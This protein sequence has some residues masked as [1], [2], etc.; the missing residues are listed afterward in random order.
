MP[1]S[2]RARKHAYLVIAHTDKGALARLLEGVDDS[3]ND[4]FVHLDSRWAVEGGDFSSCVEESG[5]SFVRRIHPA[6][7]GS[8]LIRVEL[9]L[10]RAATSSGRY[11]YYH[12]L[13][14][15]D[16]PVKS[17]DYIH[18]YFQDDG[19]TC[20]LQASDEPVGERAA[21]RFRMRYE[22]YHLLQDALIGK[23]RNAWKYLE[24]SFCHLQRLVGVRR[25]KGVQ[26]RSAWQW[27]SLPDWA[28]R[29]LAQHAGEI[30]RRWRYTYCCDELFIPTELILAGFE[31]EIDFLTRTRYAVW[32]WQG[33]R[34]SSPKV[35]TE[36]DA[37]ALGGADVLF[38]RK[39][40]S[41]RS[42]QLYEMVGKG[43]AR[44]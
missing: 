15:Q 20:Y 29:Y 42:R 35:L 12:L 21:S 16:Y 14:G 13:S 24:F 5:I 34:D 41:A 1:G 22:Q 28:A 9:E 6:W 25:F 37:A 27:F 32:E 23:S 11:S 2:G 3:R 44:G 8:R 17:Q 38:A 4:V 18:D 39:F 10:L 40:S 33:F 36:D 43:S 19:T 30:A 31:S 26:V 7:G